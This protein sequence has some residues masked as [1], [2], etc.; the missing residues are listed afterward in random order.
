[1]QYFNCYFSFCNLTFFNNYDNIGANLKGE[2]YMNE[3]VSTKSFDYDKSILNLLDLF[4]KNGY[5]SVGYWK[6]DIYSNATLRYDHNGEL[7]IY[8]QERFHTSEKEAKEMWEIDNDDVTYHH[9]YV[10]NEGSKPFLCH[11]AQLVYS[12]AV[13]SDYAGNRHR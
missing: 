13:E 9:C 2:I 1:M 11:L 7:Y 6:K 3:I 8:V 4:Y 10:V 12:T 5:V